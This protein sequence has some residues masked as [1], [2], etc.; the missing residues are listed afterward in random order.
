MYGKQL[1]PHCM[2]VFTY[3]NTKLTRAEGLVT[4]QS[5]A[6]VCVTLADSI[7]FII[8]N[9]KLRLHFPR[10]EVSFSPANQK[11]LYSSLNIRH[12]ILQRTK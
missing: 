11:T 1:H 4:V 9:H 6:D 7:F 8:N 2:N 5:F 3:L 10:V 12:K